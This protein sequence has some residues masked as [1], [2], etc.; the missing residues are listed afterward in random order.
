MSFSLFA[1]HP[2]SGNH[3]VKCRFCL[4]MFTSL[5]AFEQDSHPHSICIAGPWWVCT[6]PSTLAKDMQPYFQQ[7]R[8]WYL[9]NCASFRDISTWIFSY[10]YIDTCTNNPRRIMHLVHS[11]WSRD[12]S[13][14]K[15][16]HREV[17]SLFDAQFWLQDMWKRPTILEILCICIKTDST[18]QNQ[19]SAVWQIDMQKIQTQEEKNI[20]LK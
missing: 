15:S 16:W 9:F 3:S 2:G 18:W 13:T 4:P 17:G 19:T 11:F 14:L 20:N 7:N 10:T 1:E 6:S 12:S 8:D 5:S